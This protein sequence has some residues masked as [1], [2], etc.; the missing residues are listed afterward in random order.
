MRTTALGRARRMF[1]KNGVL[2]RGRND[3]TSSAFLTFFGYLFLN[4]GTVIRDDGRSSGS[5]GVFVVDWFGAHDVDTVTLLAKNPSI[6]I[7]LI[8]NS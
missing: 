6:F 5:I 3:Y 2:L 8:K 4:D 1:N 7:K